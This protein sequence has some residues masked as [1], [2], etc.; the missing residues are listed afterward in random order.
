VARYDSRRVIAAQLSGIAARCAQI[1]AI[2]RDEAL[3]QMR[4]T[5]TTAGIKPGTE[6]AEMVLT[7]AAETYAIDDPGPL[8]WYYDDAVRL[9]VE[10][11]A[12]EQKARKARRERPGQGPTAG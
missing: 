12:D 7:L 8:R 10:A 3:A 2:S 1:G 11:G 4:S 9:L 5:L 6:A